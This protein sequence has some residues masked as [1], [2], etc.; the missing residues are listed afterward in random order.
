MTAS[1]G[2]APYTVKLDADSARELAQRGGTI[3]LLDV[4]ENTAVGVDQQTFLVGPKFKG[5]KM[6]PPGTHVISYTSGSGQGDF[7]PTTSFFL[8]IRASEVVV[9]KWNAPEEVL[10]AM[11]DEDEVERYLLGVRSFQLD[12]HLAPYDLNSWNGWRQLSGH[13]SADVVQAVQPLGGNMSI[14]AEADPSLLRP[15]TAAE[16][17]LYEQLQKGREAKAA[18]AAAAAEAA[19]AGGQALTGAA[20]GM[21]VD[22]QPTTGAAPVAAAEQQQQQQQQQQ[23]EG[24]ASRVSAAPH[25]GRCYYTPLPRLV[26]RGGLTPQELTALNLDKSRLLEEVLAKHYKGQEAAFLG[27]FQFAFLAF[28]LGQ[29]MEGFEQ[30]KAFLCLM[31]GC[32]DAPLGPRARLFTAF[33]Q[34]LHAQLAHGLALGHPKSAQPQPLG[35]PLVDELLQ[36]S[37]LRRL[38]TQFFQML[39]E[40]RTQVIPSLAEQARAVSSVLQHTLGWGVQVVTD[41]ESDGEDEDAPVVVEARYLCT[42]N[43]AGDPKAACRMSSARQA[44]CSR[45][46]R[47]TATATRPIA[48]PR[49]TSFAGQHVG[50]RRQ[51]QQ[52]QQ[53]QHFA[54]AA[55]PQWRRQGRVHSAVSPVATAAPSSTPVPTLDS[56]DFFAVLTVQGFVSPK[57][58]EGTQAT[59]FAVY[60][61]ARIMQYVGFSRGLRDTLRTL[62]SRRPD[63]AHYYKALHLPN[64]DQQQMIDIR[65][66]WFDA[67]YGPPPGNKLPA[68]RDQWQQPVD[69]FSISERGKAQAA[70]ELSKQLQQR[71]EARGCREAFLPN[72]ELLAIGKVDFLPAAALTPEE[73]ERQRAKAA[74]TAK[75]TRSVTFELDGEPAA[76][77]L[78]YENVIKTNGGHMFDVIVTFQDKETHHRIIVGKDYY[79]PLNIEPQ[80][81]VERVFAFLLRSK[82]QRHT[83][84]M[85]LQTQF[86]PNYF[87]VSQVEQ[88]FEGFATEF[89]DVG[90]LPG[91]NS[92]WRFNRTQDYG[93]KGANETAEQLQANFS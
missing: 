15:A 11:D 72:E 36:D 31:F 34:A 33:L 76:F 13:I 5:I 85:L 4:P 80:E 90:L 75:L 60:D 40:E 91:S 66:A 88:N 84:G 12:Q 65:A 27:E 35:E 82:V 89:E 49:R 74:E 30:W 83:E 18:A 63:K 3:L 70:L 28:L 39:H 7:G 38:S 19:A 78:F 22:R 59:V 53:H 92:F 58:P 24:E 1:P 64:L 54:R 55:A 8:T 77:D 52:Q 48:V 10:E 14:L 73:L 56:L 37:F 79:E 9:R 25:A 21:Q 51:Q 20:T 46:C 26:K 32:D 62:F 86:S 43:K 44:V 2:A 23:Q 57:I 6:V 16:A 50:A 47:Q 42:R 61:E 81:T 45:S 87:S 71:I 93:Y 29:S 69:V 67:N 68:E 41:L 17:A